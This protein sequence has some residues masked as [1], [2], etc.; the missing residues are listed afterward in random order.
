MNPPAYL[1]YVVL[2]ANIATIVAVLM[3]AR[4]ALARAR[5]ADGDARMLRLLAALLVAWFALV[6]ALTYAGVLRGEADRPPIVPFAIFLPIVIGLVLLWRSDAVRRLIDAVPLSWLVGIQVYRVVGA[7]FLVLLAEGRLSPLFALPAGVGD[8]TVG[9]LA[10]F[11]AWRYARGRH[12]RTTLVRAWNVAGLLDLAIAVTAGFLTV[13]SPLQPASLIAPSS[14]LLTVFPLA[15]V[16]AFAVPVSVILHAAA[17]I[18]L[19]GAA[20][21]DGARRRDEPFPGHT[22][23]A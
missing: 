5:M 18:K 17:L 23:A 12:G 8:V 21:D 2:T 16:P 10:P 15:L 22:K 7:I 9:V 3:G 4:A 1:A 19:R 20:V 6:L 11:V 13:P 14:A